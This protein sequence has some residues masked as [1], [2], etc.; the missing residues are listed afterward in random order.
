MWNPFRAGGAFRYFRTAVCDGQI[1]NALQE[2]RAGKGEV[3]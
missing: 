2:H 3:P 1:L